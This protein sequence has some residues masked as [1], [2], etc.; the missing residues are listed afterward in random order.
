MGKKVADDKIKD[1]GEVKKVSVTK[2][3]RGHG[4]HARIS[5]EKEIEVRPGKLKVPSPEALAKSQG[6]GC[7]DEA[8]ESKVT[9]TSV[10]HKDGDPIVE[11]TGEVAIVVPPS[12]DITKIAT[13]EGA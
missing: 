3:W 2:K 12:G 9:I 8:V 7:D 10:D 5:Y 1:T 11:F 13:K 4:K 6:R